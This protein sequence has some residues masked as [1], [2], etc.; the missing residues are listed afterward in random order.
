LNTFEIDADVPLSSA[1][2][3]VV[4]PLTVIGFIEHF[5][6]LGTKGGIIHTAAASS[7]G[8]QLVKICNK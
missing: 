3:G 4:N 2:S 7:L 8:K 5:K 1:A 6:T